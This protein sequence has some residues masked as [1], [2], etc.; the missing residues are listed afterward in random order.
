MTT[1]KPF[2]DWDKVKIRFTLDWK[3]Q[4]IH[5]WYD[6]AQEKGYLAKENI[7]LTIDQGDGS[8]YTVTRIM[9][10][11]YDAGFGGVNAFIQ[12]TFKRIDIAPVMVHIT[13]RHRSRC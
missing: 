12:N 11:T 1:G 7:E 2:T 6:W 3:L 9:S 8:A 4:G 13:T 10:G 5:A